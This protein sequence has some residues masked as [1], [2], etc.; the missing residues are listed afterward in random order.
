MRDVLEREISAS[1]QF[2]IIML[3]AL[4]VAFFWMLPGGGN[5]EYAVAIN[6]TEAWKNVAPY[7]NSVLLI[8]VALSVLRLAAIFLAHSF[9]RKGA[10]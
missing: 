6:M 1:I 10:K 3:F 4:V 8:F 5:G 9:F 2:F 7:V